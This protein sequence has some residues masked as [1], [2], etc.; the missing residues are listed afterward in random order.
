MRMTRLQEPPTRRSIAQCVMLDPS[1]PHQWLRCSGFVH[2]SNNSRAPRW[3][4]HVNTISRSD[5][6]V[7]WTSTPFPTS[8]LL[9]SLGFQLSQVL[10]EPVHAVLP[11]ATILLDPLGDL[12]QGSAFEMTRPPLRNAAATNQARAFQH[13]EVFGHGRRGDRK[14]LCELLDR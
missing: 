9:S 11:R 13:L 12:S 10:V 5:G 8:M 7:T 4:R 14:R 2:A 1:Q 3:K 6:R